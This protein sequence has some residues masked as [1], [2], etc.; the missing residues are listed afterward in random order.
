MILNVRNTLAPLALVAVILSSTACKGD[1]KGEEKEVSKE[2]AKKDEKREPVIKGIASLDTERKQ[3]SYM[4]GMDIGKSIAPV[5]DEVDMETLVEAMKT[6][7]K[8]GKPLLTDEQAKQV[9]QAFGERMMAKQAAEREIAVKKNLEE[10]A[11]FLAENKKKPNVKTTE[12]GLQYQILRPGNGPKPTA[13]D[14]VL[15]HYVGTF[16]DG[17]KFDS[18]YDRGQPAEFALNAVI[19]GWTEGLQLMSKGSK[20]KFW[21]PAELAYG[22]EGQGAMPP[23]ATLVFEVEL[24][25][26]KAGSAQVMPQ[27]APQQ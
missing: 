6:V 14:T 12:S 9:G 13:N 24:Q 25:D 4:I 16:L 3:F 11:K 8:D 5:K 22:A 18:S 17:K 26:V 21:I 19:P 23:N 27:E 15:A 7:M 10:G 1:S 2:A 20:F